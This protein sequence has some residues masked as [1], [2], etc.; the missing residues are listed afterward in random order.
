MGMASLSWSE[1]EYSS[2]VLPMRSCWVYVSV[3]LCVKDTAEPD[4]SLKSNFA[5]ISN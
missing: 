5:K 1:K 4:I 2:T 3:L